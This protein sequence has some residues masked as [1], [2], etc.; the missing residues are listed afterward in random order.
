MLT[1]IQRLISLVLR[2]L[3]VGVGLLF[4]AALVAAGVVLTLVLV[5]WSLLRGRRP[6]VV[7]FHVDPRAP[8][9][10]MRRGPAQ[11]PGE[12]VDIEAREV[13]DTPAQLKRDER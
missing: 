9:A 8:F 13:P 2:L 4:A 7:R 3:L 5:I 11:P 1:F 6:R 10:G 12:V